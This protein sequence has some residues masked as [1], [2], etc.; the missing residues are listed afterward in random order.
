MAI[1]AGETM[2]D[3]AR[4]FEGKWTLRNVDRRWGFGP[5]SYKSPMNRPLITDIGPQ[6]GGHPNDPEILTK[7]LSIVIP[8][9]NEEEVLTETT[10][11]MCALLE[12]LESVGKISPESAVWFVDD[13]S[14]DETWGLIERMAS[15]YRY[16]HG[17]KL[18]R[19]CGHQ[20][21]LLAGL[22]SVPGDV[23]ISIDADLQDDLGV[24]EQMLDAH[25]GG[26]EIVYGVRQSRTT[27]SFFK[28]QTAE[29]YYRLVKGMGVDV[30]F[31][32]ADYRLM[33]RRAIEALR[34]FEEVNLFLRGLIPQLG[35]RS[36]SVYYD[37][38]ER[39]AGV[40]KYPLGKMLA[41]AWQGVTS[42]SAVP[43][44]IITSL[45][46]MVSL[47]SFGFGAWAL[48]SKLFTDNALP[49][50]ASTVLPI[51]FLGG[52]QLLCIGIIG[53]YVAKMYLET[54]RRPRY[55]IEKSV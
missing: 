8:C 24:M 18:S 28:R 54:K 47:V 10:R 22:L 52:I 34:Q 53:E 1:L 11:R 12:R 33:G 42:F 39:F 13:G 29:L 48:L 7:T 36:A 38:A 31:N 55:L 32:H 4:P 6:G 20:N 3:R 5:Q 40:S 21:A 19:N 23:T 35:F 43:L 30:V 26:A 44:R 25:R 51:Y 37:R 14:R 46:W 49:G 16:V 27:D 41:F 45:G 9:F 2:P 15:E 50:W 17:L